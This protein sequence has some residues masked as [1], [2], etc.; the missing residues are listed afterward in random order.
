MYEGRKGR[1]KL[2]LCCLLVEV[3]SS[4]GGRG[5]DRSGTAL[6]T[7]I[8]GH[9]VPCHEGDDFWVPLEEGEDLR[10]SQPTN[11]IA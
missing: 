8:S 9:F 5:G 4:R 10:K 11:R 7:A 6:T 3:G 2:T 1:K